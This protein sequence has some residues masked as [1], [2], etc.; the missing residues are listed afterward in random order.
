MCQLKTIVQRKV[1][2]CSVQAAVSSGERQG[3]SSL[4]IFPSQ[5]HAL[6]VAKPYQPVVGVILFSDPLS[7]SCSAP[8]L[9]PLFLGRFTVGK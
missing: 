2:R 8:P 3:V 9:T 6:P 7:V 1:S 4:H 5:L